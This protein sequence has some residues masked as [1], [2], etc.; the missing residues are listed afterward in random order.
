MTQMEN[1][2]TR[3]HHQMAWK[4]IL[5]FLIAVIDVVPGRSTPSH[6]KYVEY[7]KT[8]VEPLPIRQYISTD[9]IGSHF[10]KLNE[11]NIQG[12]SHGDSMQRIKRSLGTTAIR[13][14][15]T[16]W[17]GGGWRAKSFE[18]LGAYGPTD[19]C[20]RQH[21]LGCPAAIQP[22]EELLGLKNDRFFTMMHCSCDERFRSCLKMVGAK[23]ANTVG[24]LFF[25]LMRTPC[26]ILDQEKI[27][28]EYTWWGKCI[29]EEVKRI[30]VMKE[31]VPF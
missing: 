12:L 9:N 19:K 18:H 26:F 11:T 10:L 24:K 7:V 2:F 21:D 15:G 8:T 20:C 17:C 31:P 5:L 13:M 14:P 29:K 1:M 30:A 25:N 28:T 23:N 6:Q 27:C 3:S 22:G 4:I 16:N